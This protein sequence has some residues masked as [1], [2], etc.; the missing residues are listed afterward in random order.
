MIASGKMAGHIAAFARPSNAMHMT[1][2]E[3]VVT[4][5]RRVS[6]MPSIA[7]YFRKFCCE[8]YL[9]INAI[10]EKI[11]EQHRRQCESGEIFCL[12]EVEA[13]RLAVNTDD[14]AG[15]HFRAYIKEDGQGAHYQV[16]ILPNAGASGGNRSGA[17][18]GLRFGACINFGQGRAPDHQGQQGQHH[19][20]HHIRH[21]HAAGQFLQQSGFDGGIGCFV[22]LGF[23]GAGVF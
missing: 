8:T 1:A 15:H 16:R 22:D 20:H 11:A 2:L 5:V 14:V 9:G 12:V 3:P 4:R 10:S 23:N 13:E 18:V 6:T 19:S 7:E 21:H 17:A